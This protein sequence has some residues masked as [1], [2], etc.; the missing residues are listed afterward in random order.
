MRDMLTRLCRTARLGGYLA[1]RLLLESVVAPTRASAFRLQL[2]RLREDAHRQSRIPLRRLA[3][4]WPSPGPVTVEAD[5]LREGNP[6]LIELFCLG[7]IARGTG[8]R[9]MFEIGT[10][11]GTT[12]LQLALNSPSDAVIHTLDLPF[13]G[14]DRTRRPILSQ[15]RRYVLKPSSGS[16][17]LGTPAQ[18]KIRQLFGDSARFSAES[19]AAQMDLVVVDG[20]HALDYV[21]SDS[22]LARTLARPGGWIVWHDYGV[23]PDVTTGL[24]ELAN[25]LPLV[26]LES[27]TLVVARVPPGP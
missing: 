7:V 3:D 23:W 25:T 4:L 27:T 6:T 14:V 26:R 17:F 19:F 8:A 12:T 20:S 1:Q 16:R 11:D 13:G 15:E 5:D 9:V 2:E 22:L 18:A 10:F 24:L 21:R